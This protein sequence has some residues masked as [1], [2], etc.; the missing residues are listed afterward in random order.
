MSNR[1]LLLI[2][3]WFLLTVPVQA[4]DYYVATDGIDEPERGLSDDDPFRTIMYALSVADTTEGRPHTIYIAEG[5]Y[6]GEQEILPLPMIDQVSLIGAGPELTILDASDAPNNFITS[7]NASDWSVEDLTI[8]GGISLLGGG[9]LILNGENVLLHNLVIR[10]NRADHPF[11]PNFEGHGGGVYVEGTE[12]ITIDHVLFVGNSALSD[13]GALSAELCSP[14]LSYVTMVDNV[15]D[16]DEHSSAIFHHTN[17]QHEI[18][19]RNSVIWRNFYLLGNDESISADNITIEYSLVEKSGYPEP[20]PGEGNIWEDPLFTDFEGRDFTVLNG[21]RV[22]DLAD[23]D[24][25]FE[26]EPEN[27]GGRANSGFYGNTETAQ[28]STIDLTMS[29]SKWKLI[30]LPVVPESGDPQELFGDDFNNAL[31]G[32]DTWRLQWW[33]ASEQM[34]LRYGEVEEDGSEHGD[35]PALA[36]GMGFL[37]R[38]NMLPRTD[39]TVPGYA[40]AQ[41]EAYTVELD[42]GEGLTYQMIAN[43]YPYRVNW[44]DILVNTG[45]GSGSFDILTESGRGSRYAYK[46]NQDGRFAPS[47]APLEPWEAVVVVTDGGDD[48]SLEFSPGRTD[49]DIGE[50][51]IGADWAITMGVT[52]LDDEDE[53][54]ESSQGHMFGIGEVFSDSVDWYDAR[55]IDWFP[56]RLSVNW[57]ARP[58]EPLHSDFR[59]LIEEE[60]S[61]GW[62]IEILSAVLPTDSTTDIL[63]DSA[64]LIFYGFSDDGDQVFPD[65]IY[66]FWITDENYTTIIDDLRDSTYFRLPMEAVTD[67]LKRIGLWLFVGNQVNDVHVEEKQPVLA[68]ESFHITSV[69]PNPFNSTTTLTC[70]LPERSPV[71]LSVYDLLGRKVHAQQ[72]A[73][74]ES[75]THKL[76]WNAEQMSSG[77]YF[78][79]VGTRS[80]FAL[81]KVVLVK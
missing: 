38:Q 42:G 16:D 76:S 55:V 39:I 59:G 37:V 47:V 78:V 29:R 81:R 80:S 43:P 27:N 1:F 60:E 67:S 79:R 75:G 2:M 64:E 21:S 3:A 34:F 77:T 51:Q 68:P 49:F 71:S 19:I 53:I 44:T 74:K 63:P 12:E 33:S 36:P 14:D 7:V 22:I 56:Q 62:H 69:Y 5:T 23:P 40:L 15:C 50:M 52:T 66:N 32:E 6:T 41:Y 72:Y 46:I 65:S 20:W 54:L 48:I 8:T 30:G 11:I 61:E 45:T 57:T 70:F 28:H 24:D 18:M 26:N 10:D 31:P 73:E 17:A 35:P 13:G 58:R 4:V 25:P 9:I